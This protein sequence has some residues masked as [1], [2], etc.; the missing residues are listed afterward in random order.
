[1]ITALGSFHGGPSAH[2]RLQAAK[3][4]VTPLVPA[5]TTCHGDIAALE[6]AVT[7]RR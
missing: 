3:Y 7:R 1:M 4:R 6:E 2:S 5:S